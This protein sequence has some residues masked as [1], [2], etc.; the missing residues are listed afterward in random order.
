MD[1][2]TIAAT[3]YKTIRDRIRA[4]DPQIDEQTLADTI[5]GL[6]DLHEILAA[7][8]RAALADEAMATGLKCRIS[9]MQGRLD[10]LQDRAAK[11]RQIAKDAMVELDLK[12]LAA[13][14]FT[15]S[16]RPGMPALVVLNED[17]VPKTYWEPGEP[18][19]RRQILAS[20]LK[21]GAEVSGATLSNPEPVLSVRTR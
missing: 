3:T 9:D 6:T 1:Q 15:A 13:P 20:D 16:I 21:G 18:R 10:R 17:A 2:L 19:L 14:D 4:Q 7:V 12:K 5:E 11:R 8:L